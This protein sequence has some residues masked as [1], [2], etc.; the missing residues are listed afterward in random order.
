MPICEK[1]TNGECLA[2]NSCQCFAGYMW[3]NTTNDC[4]P[5]CQSGC[6]NGICKAPETCECFP[7]YFPTSLKNVCEPTCN[8]AC[9]L[10]KCISIN[11]CE[12]LQGYHFVQGSKSVCE[13]HCTVPCSS[14][15]CSKSPLICDE[16]I[17]TTSTE[18]ISETDFID[19][20]SSSTESM[21]ASDT[22]QD[23]DCQKTLCSPKICSME[24]PSIDC[25]CSSEYRIVNDTHC[26]P[27]CS[28][29]TNYCICIAPNICTCF[30]GYR[31]SDSDP[32]SCV[33]D[34]DPNQL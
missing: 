28:K 25:V 14:N 7:G 5:V 10:S 6:L 20:S 16:E 12:C 33:L 8:P 22:I 1:C 9:E 23:I 30:V 31:P 24:Q 27:V 17:S 4:S 29:N 18:I 32:F 34:D 19:Y 2:P 3:N 11:T 21:L 26:A 13:P 15:N